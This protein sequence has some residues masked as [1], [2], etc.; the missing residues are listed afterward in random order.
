MKI[1]P[2]CHNGDWDSHHPHHARGG[3][4]NFFFVSIIW[5]ILGSFGIFSKLGFYHTL[6][7][8][9][10]HNPEDAM[11]PWEVGG[12]VGLQKVGE[13]IQ[14]VGWK[15]FRSYFGS[16]TQQPPAGSGLQPSPKQSHGPRFLIYQQVK[17]YYC[18]KNKSF[19]FASSS[20]RLIYQQPS[21]KQDIYNP[22]NQHIHYYHHILFRPLI[23]KM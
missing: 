20:Q 17:S 13:N 8:G 14:E 9:V 4:L 12:Y 16:I 3:Q 19:A 11:S 22:P 18:N 2:Q 21:S 5:D 10:G 6:W 15:D 7:A 23:V 1:F